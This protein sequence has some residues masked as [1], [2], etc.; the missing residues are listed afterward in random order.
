MLKVLNVFVVMLFVLLASAAPY[1]AAKGAD[2]AF[3]QNPEER[4]S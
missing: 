1:E 4:T 3:A 2:L